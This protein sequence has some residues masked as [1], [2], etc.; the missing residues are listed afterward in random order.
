MLLVLLLTS[1]QL[2]VQILI[3]SYW[4]HSINE[5]LVN[6]SREWF[7]ELEVLCCLKIP[8]CLKLDEDIILTTIH[9]FVDV[10]PNK[11]QL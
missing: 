9:M 4:D 3:H 11:V 7:R 8:M 10:P 2:I 1:L 5:I 6:K